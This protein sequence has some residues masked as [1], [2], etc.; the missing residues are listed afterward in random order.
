MK[1]IAIFCDGTWNR[2]EA[3]E[4]TNVVR[5]AQAVKLT[6]D[7]GRSQ[8]VFYVM[9]VGN[10]RGSNALARGLDRF[11]GSTMGFGLIENIEDAWRALAFCYEPGDALYING[12]SRGAYTARSLAGLIRSC[13]IPPRENLHRI[14]EGLA[15]YRSRQPGTH[16]ASAESYRFRA[17]LSPYTATSQEEWEWRRVHAPG[18]CVVLDIAYLG[19]WDTVGAL[20][21]PGYW[22]VA[23]ILNTAYQ[24]HDTELSHSVASARHAV[25]IDERRRTFPPALW[26]NLDRLNR[27]ALGLGAH[28][29]LDG[30]P[31][32][33][34]PYRE[35]WFPGDHGSV[36]GGGDI[37]G[38][39]AAS[40][41]Y[42]AEGAAAAGLD[43]RPEV[44]AAVA[45]ER[46]ILA[47]VINCSHLSWSRKLLALAA[48]DRDGPD[49]MRRL[50]AATQERLR[51]DAGYKPKTLSKI[52]SR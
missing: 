2:A 38:L 19:V 18:M 22:S 27:R 6:A 16:P 13:G 29:P 52:L 45:A 46:D 24:F 41:G 30:I 40:Y 11:F 7:D 4:P 25:S 17:E 10:G 23:P 1:R 34:L 15:R 39:S 21:V 32:D 43:L 31:V 33:H 50:S 36:G 47:P 48:K 37:K 3:P 26:S 14:G 42:I 28:D 44:L 9:G 20:G 8:Q 35:E 49:G 51:Q 5:L 12:F